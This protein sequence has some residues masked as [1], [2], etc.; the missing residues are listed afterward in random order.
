MVR[1]A[2]SNAIEQHAAVA[3]NAVAIMVPTAGVRI[4]AVL[5]A[6][7]EVLVAGVVSEEVV[8]DLGEVVAGARKLWGDFWCGDFPDARKPRAH[9]GEVSRRA[10]DTESPRPRAFL[11]TDPCNPWLKS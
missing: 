5:G 8:V 10:H 2:H 9:F 4:E 1:S 6:T 11:A 7:E 3:R